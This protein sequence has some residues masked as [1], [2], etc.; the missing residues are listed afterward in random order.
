MLAIWLGEDNFPNITFMYLVPA[1]VIFLSVLQEFYSSVNFY[2]NG[3]NKVTILIIIQIFIKLFFIFF[4]F[5][6]F[7]ELAPVVGWMVALLLTI[8]FHR[9]NSLKV[10][11]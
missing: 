5:E 9:Q 6:Q 4:L 2:T 11:R 7:R 8:Y 3:L 10:L 1:V